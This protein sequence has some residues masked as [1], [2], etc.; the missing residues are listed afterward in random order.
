MNIVFNRIGMIILCIIFTA[1]INIR[2][3]T[4]SMNVEG[5]LSSG[6]RYKFHGNDV[7]TFSLDELVEQWSLHQ[8]RPLD[9]IAIARTPTEVAEHGQHHFEK[10]RLISLHDLQQL[11]D[12]LVFIINV[13][14]CIASSNWVLYLEMYMKDGRPP[15]PGRPDVLVIDIRSGRMYGYTQ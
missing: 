1:S 3:G 14:I 8:I 2:D 11:G 6:I 10:A 13:W 5:T 12:E 9:A 15:P 7:G 4:W